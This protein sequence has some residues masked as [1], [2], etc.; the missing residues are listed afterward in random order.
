MTHL[1]GPRTY[2]PMTWDDVPVLGG[3]FSDGT[4]SNSLEGTFYGDNHEEVG[5]IFERNQIIGAFGASRQ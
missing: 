5:G 3:R 4:G 2:A 1:T